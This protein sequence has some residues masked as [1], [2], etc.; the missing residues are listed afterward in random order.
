MVN[1]RNTRRAI[2]IGSV[3]CLVSAVL[4]LLILVPVKSIGN[5]FGV[6]R[7]TADRDK[8]AGRR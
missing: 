4:G 1:V 6:V 7:Q 5:W 2:G 3:I 8:G